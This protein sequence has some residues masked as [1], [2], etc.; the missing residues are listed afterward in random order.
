MNPEEGE[1]RPQLLD[2][3]GLAVDVAAGKDIDERVEVVARRMAFDADQHAFVAAHADAERELAARI[4]AARTALPSV[5][6]PTSELRR[7][8][9]ICAHLDVDGLRGDIVVARTAA[10]HAAWRGAT[11]V[12]ESDVRAAVELALPHR[13]RRNPFDE[14]GLTDE[15]LDDA[16][17]AGAEATGPDDP[18]PDDPNPD[19]RGPD[20]DGPGGDGPD[21][22]ADGPEPSPNTATDTPQPPDSAAGEND[23]SSQPQ[24]V[25]GPRFGPA[26][27]LIHISEPTRPY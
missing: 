15:Q 16:R 9:G 18:G 8:A 3:F 13:R 23:S 25:P 27:S 20:D 17:N 6:V 19:D 4:A 5:T 11:S 22:A 12:D 26:L 2:R 21:G 24:T 7:I 1:L 14:S 10:A